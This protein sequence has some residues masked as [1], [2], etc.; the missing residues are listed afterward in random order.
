MKTP[1][2]YPVTPGE[3]LGQHYATTLPV[4]TTSPEISRDFVHP[5]GW[6]VHV[7]IRGDVIT[8]DMDGIFAVKAFGN[9][10]WVRR[11]KLKEIEE[12][13]ARKGFTPVEIEKEED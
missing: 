12:E 6:S 9:S 4:F 13:L 7:E 11:C 5:D 10:R 1:E 8:L 3:L 2:I